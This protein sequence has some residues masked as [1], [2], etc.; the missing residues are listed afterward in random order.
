[1]QPHDSDSERPKTVNLDGRRNPESSAFFRALGLAFAKIL[2]AN[3]RKVHIA[4]PGEPFN[5]SA[6]IAGHGGVDGK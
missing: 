3:H 2:N 5:M 4:K 1:M 6:S